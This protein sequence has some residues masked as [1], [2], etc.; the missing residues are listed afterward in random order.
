MAC[1]F[2]NI[3]YESRVLAYDNIN[4]PEK[5]A[6]KKMLPIMEFSN[7]EVSNESL[8]IVAKLDTENNLFL[9][10]SDKEVKIYENIC[11]EIGSFL[12]PLAMPSWLNTPE[13][14]N[15]SKKYFR[16]K[17]E[18]KRGPFTDLVKRAPELRED[19]YLFLETFSVPSKF[20]KGEY[21]T[22]LD[23]MVASHLYGIYTLLDFCVPKTIHEFLQRVKVSCG[24]SYHSDFKIDQDFKHWDAK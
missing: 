9:S 23:I 21:L 8:D 14:F 2:L 18:K 6:G 13:F 3:P 19:L 24:F 16:E 12:H 11:N 17:K 10:V 15:E 1:D 22:I 5:L 4:L 7:G 20:I